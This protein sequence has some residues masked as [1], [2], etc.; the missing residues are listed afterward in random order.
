MKKIYN[1]TFKLVCIYIICLSIFSIFNLE[2]KVKK[3]YNNIQNNNQEIVIESNLFAQNQQEKHDLSEEDEKESINEVETKKEEIKVSTEETKEEVIESTPIPTPTPTPTPKV[4]EVVNIV[5]T[6]SFAVLSNETVNISHYG[7]DCY[8]CTTG[9]TASGYYV[10]DGRI[11][12]QDPTF[13]TVRVV[14]ADRKYPLGTIVRLR[15]HG[16]TITAIV[17]D[18]GGGIGDGKKFQIDLLTTSNSHALQLGIVTNTTLEVL[19]LGY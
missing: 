17:L 9:H 3:Y 7:H 11:Y 1:Y 6:S 19:R 13:G 2:I 12:Y 14:A 5:D 8:G 16:S 4:E 10:G 15:Y 18:R